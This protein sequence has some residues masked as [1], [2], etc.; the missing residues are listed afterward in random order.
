[1]L[2][3]A[4][5]NKLSLQSGTLEKELIMK[6]KKS[7]TI[8]AIA[9]LVMAITAFVYSPSQ[10]AVEVGRGGPPNRQ[11]Q[12]ANAGGMTAPATLSEQE[13]ADLA[14]AIQEEY[15][16]MNTYQAI[17]EELGDVQPFSRIA[18]AE[19]QHVNALIRVAE[20]FGVEVPENAGEVAE[21]EWNTLEE[22]CQL[23]VTFEQLDADLYDVLMANTT[24]PMLTRVYTNLQ[25]A[26]LEQHLPA[27][28][29]CI[30]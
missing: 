7:I 17:M 27:F 9:I 21:I 24:N 1:M 28:E 6:N 5:L 19:Q 26:S 10:A 4:H 15:T 14:E 23:G 3:Q 25:R 18:R 12:P 8:I 29:A 20:R 22:A 30:P 2:A 16:A 11:S 13:A